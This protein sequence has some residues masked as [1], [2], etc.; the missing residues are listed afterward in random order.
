M[1]ADT[2]KYLEHLV[3]EY[4]DTIY[5]LAMSRTKNKDNA[6]DVYQEVFLRLAK[7]LPIFESKKHEKAW[8]IKV[9]INCSKNILNSKHSRNDVELKDTDN[10]MPDENDEKNDVYY[11]VLELPLKYRTVIYLFYYEGYRIEEMS[12]ILNTNVNTIKSWLSRARKKLKSK[13][14]GGLEDE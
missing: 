3:E 10:V 12:K 8:I 1:H 9:T 13:I 11:A 4:S 2:N 7:K 14:G 5:R 6:E